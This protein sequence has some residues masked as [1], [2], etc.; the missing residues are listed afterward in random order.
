MGITVTVHAGADDA[1]IAWNADFITECRGFA[2]YRRI[3]RAAGGDGKPQHHQHG[4]GRHDRGNCRE[5]GRL[6]RRTRGRTGDATADHGVAHPEV[7]V[8]GLRGGCWRRG[9]LS[10]G[11]YDRL[12]ERPGASR[13]PGVAV[14]RQR[15]DRPQGRGY[16]LL[17]FQPRH[18]REPMGG[19]AIAVAARPQGRH[20][21]QERRIAQEH[22]DARQR[23]PRFPVRRRPHRNDPTVA[24]GERGRRARLS[25]AV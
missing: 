5:L 12:V 6:C 19:A 23:H 13:C 17:L 25:G 10:R 22:C 9:C 14:E 18:R 4:G 3:K 8:V 15:R 2:L 21:R 16:R 24:G 11:A 20:A 7:S 1:F